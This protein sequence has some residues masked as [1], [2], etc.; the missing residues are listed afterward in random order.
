[1]IRGI[2]EVYSYR[3]MLKSLVKKDLRTRYKGSFLGFLWTFVN[4][5]LQLAVYT[6]IFSSIMRV[7]IDKFYMYLFVALVPWIFF[8]TSLQISTGSIV[9]NKDLV[10][11]IYFPRVVLPI[12]VVTANLMNMI[13]SFAVVIPALLLS[14]I[15]INACILYLPL[16]MLIEYIMALGFSILFSALNVY[17]RDLEHLLGIILMAWFYFTP[18]VYSIDMIPPAYMKLFKLNPITPVIL[19][20]REILYFKRPPDMKALGISL[21]IGVVLLF[22]ADKVFYKLQKNFAEEI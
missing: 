6:V 5:L 15:G 8:S 9:A 14:G 17:F 2:K 11:K 13:F 18:I 20:Y 16:I 19:A 10:K 12:S 21:L 3:E 7:D 4:P 22:I 1:M